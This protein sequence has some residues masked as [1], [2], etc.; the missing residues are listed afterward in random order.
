MALVF[1]M[2]FFHPTAQVQAFSSVSRLGVPGLSKPAWQYSV[3]FRQLHT[4]PQ[5]SCCDPVL[6]APIVEVQR[7]VRLRELSV[8]AITRAS[9]HQLEATKCF[10][11]FISVISES[12][13]EKYADAV[14]FALQ[15]KLHCGNLAGVPIAVKDNFCT[16]EMP[17]TCASRILSGAEGKQGFTPPY[18]ST[19][20]KRLRQAGAVVIG[21]TNMDEFGMGS[22]SVHSHY[23]AVVNPWS[24]RDQKLIAG[25][26]SGG[27]AAAVA[28]LTAYGAVGSDTGGSVR[29]PA[30]YVTVLY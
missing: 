1:T 28:S 17:T 4:C 11:S 27:S 7:K 19:V 21:K 2:K 12:E 13:L 6:K 9:F 3:A 22:T 29:Q 10:N 15:N 16:T 5:V 14:D 8:Q 26:S 30:A 18:D 23:G 25:G 20:V 24:P